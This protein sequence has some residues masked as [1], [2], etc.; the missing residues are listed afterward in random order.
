M[1]RIVDQ[2]VANWGLLVWEQNGKLIE[3][4]QVCLCNGMT[5]VISPEEFF[6]ITD[7]E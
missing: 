7:N 1:I 6:A 5:L 3:Q 2:I 4:V